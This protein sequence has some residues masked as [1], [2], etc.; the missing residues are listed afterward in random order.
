MFPSAI[1][2]IEVGP[3]DGL[4]NLPAPA[5][6]SFK[7]ELIQRLYATGLT[8]VE[9]TSFVHPKWVPQ[10]ADAEAV[11]AALAPPDRA[12]VRVLIPNRKGLERARRAGVVNV[13]VNVGATETFNQHN[14]NRSVNAT[15]AEVAALCQEAKGAG[16]RVDGSVSV[17][18]GCPYEG[19][20]PQ[21][22][23]VRTA[24]ALHAMG[25]EEL[26]IADTI[27]IAHPRQVGEVFRRLRSEVPTARLAAHFHDTRG[28]A[29]ANALAALKEGITIFE[30]SLGGIG[31]C[32]FAPGASGNVS[33][34]DLLN[35]VERMGIRTG[36]DVQA[37]VAVARWAGAALQRTLPGRLL[38]VA[39]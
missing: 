8:R 11:L 38:Q 26:S 33:S 2:F 21:H 35:M 3:R 18:F 17:A 24:R 22:A 20:V 31:G 5:A 25:I 1:E 19:E 10:L 34:E 36:V 29:L 28:M 13:V 23:V 15:L 14:L 32:P 6:T 30:G 37:L 4:Q 7:I 12:R 9:A 16:I 39:S 27:G